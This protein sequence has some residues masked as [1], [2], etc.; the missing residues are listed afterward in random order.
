VLLGQTAKATQQTVAMAVYTDA[1]LFVAFECQEAT[2]EQIRANQKGRDNEVYLDDCVELFLAPYEGSDEYYHF[3]VNPAGTLQDEKGQDPAWNCKCKAKARVWASKW[4]AEIMIPFG[5]LSLDARTGPSWRVNFCREERPHDELSSWS[6]CEQGFH[7][8]GHFGLLTNLDADFVP[9]ARATMREQI[10]TCERELGPIK[11]AAN[12]VN[13]V[14]LAQDVLKRAQAVEGDVAEMRMALAAGDLDRSGLRTLDAR[15][16]ETTSELDRLAKQ[17]SRLRMVAEAKGSQRDAAFL[18]CQDSTMAKVRKDRPYA[19]VPAEGIEIHAAQNEY[20]AAQIVVVPIAQP[21][22]GV[23]AAV[24]PLRRR[25]GEGDA[26]DAEM[27]ARDV[28]VNVVG[29]VT[30]TKSSG[31]A[32]LSPGLLPDPLLEN[33]PFDVTEDEVQPIW[34]TV[35]VPPEQ[36]PGE[37]VGELEIAPENANAVRLP[38]SVNVW[39]FALPTTTRLRNAFQI[40]PSF[41]A[42]RCH[43]SLTPGSV[44]GWT[45]GVWSG[46]DSE[47]RAD[48]FGRG[49]FKGEP[50]TGGAH[51]G[52]RCL[53]IIGEAAEPGVEAPRGAYYTDPPFKVEPNTTYDL[54]L[55]YRTEGLRDGQARLLFTGAVG[56]GAALDAAPAWTEYRGELRSNDQAEMRIYV[57]SYGVGT[58]WCDDVKLVPKPGPETNAVPNG[59]FEEGDPEAGQKLLRAFRLDALEHRCSDINIASPRVTIDDNGA[60][61]I[62]WSQFDE[63]IAFYL[64][65]GLSAFNLG[66]CR[67]PAGWG[68]VRDVDETQLRQARETL[69]Q[70][71]EHLERKGWLDLAYIYTI[72]E[73][74]KTAF[75][76][77][78]AAFDLVHTAAP[79]LKTLLT[80]GYGASRPIEPGKPVYADLAGYVDIWVP[81]SDCFEPQFLAQRRERGEDIWDYV[82]ISAQRPYVNIWGIDHPGT[83]HR[84]VFWQCWRYNISGFLYWAVNYWNVDPWQDPMTYPGG[85]GDGS[86]LYFGPDG[87][88]DSIRWDIV[89]DGIEDYDYLA[90]LRDMAPQVEGQL[91]REV[92]RALDVSDMT[93]SWT[94]YTGN[95]RDIEARRLALGDLIAKVKHAARP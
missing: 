71:Q 6:R 59:T 63:E 68:T 10:T 57:Q 89:R 43:V 4:T 26:P 45:F 65:H 60:V 54:S 46:A 44:P 90:L 92:E 17:A 48:Y 13:D 27:P 3:V 23:R 79:K 31:Q 70:T 72:D 19:G 93:P 52:Q 87:P 83:D 88:V 66:W 50:V 67:V 82:C 80:L 28:T 78:K 42:Q 21:L 55:W 33:Q 94:E 40:L 8:P 61:N 56:G 29:Y 53:R 9:Y 37:Y 85:N 91:R 1:A 81:H 22:R 2:P 34:I 76:Q 25:T 84:L 35:Y 58:L 38:F 24:G 64:R 73:P 86:L 95:P 47:G 69:R 14:P 49:V 41:I 75:P 15:L 5:G 51:A 39:D 18:L 16:A 36:P 11:D 62:D 7:E 32:P 12:A 77:V 20:E 30:V 74:D